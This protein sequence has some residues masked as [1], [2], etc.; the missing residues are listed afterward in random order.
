MAIVVDSTTKKVV[1]DLTNGT[2]TISPILP[3]ATDDSVL[4]TGKAIGNILSE[5]TE[6]VKMVVTETIIDDGQ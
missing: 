3:S 5:G 6:A 1:L 4:A 2:Q